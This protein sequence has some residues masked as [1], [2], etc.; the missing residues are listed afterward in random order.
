VR[1]P[2]GRDKVAAS[3]RAAGVPIAIHYATPLHQ[4]PAY[5]RFP[6]A[7]P[8]LENAESLSQEV[9]SLPMHADLDERTQ[10]RVI[11]AI[12]EAVAAAATKPRRARA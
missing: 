5:R 4:A 2:V 8:Q 7:A 3:C 11:D 6:T 1:V 9:L 12:R 10:D